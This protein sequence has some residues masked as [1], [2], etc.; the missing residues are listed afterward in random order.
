MIPVLPA[1][2]IQI[3]PV[4]VTLIGAYMVVEAVEA[5]VVD[6]PPKED[7]ASGRYGAVFGQL[8]AAGYRRFR[9]LDGGVPNGMN[10]PDY[11]PQLRFYTL[12]WRDR[13]IDVD[14]DDPA[15]A[16]AS[17]QG[18]VVVTCDARYL[19]VV[20]ALGPALTTVADC[21][22]ASPGPLAAPRAGS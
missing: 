13:G 17:G 2:P 12:V 9:T 18:M 4:L 11:N 8:Q 19:G 7:L 20:R 21:A 10:R 15:H 14:A 5:K 6:L 16:A 22:A 3:A 1:W